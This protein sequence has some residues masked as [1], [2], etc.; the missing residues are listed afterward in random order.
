VLSWS[1]GSLHGTLPN[2]DGDP[3]CF[4]AAKVIWWRRMSRSM[5]QDVTEEIQRQVVGN[6]CEV[7][8]LGFAQTDFSG[9][10]IDQPSAVRRGENK[11]VQLRLA[12]KIGLR[13]PATLVTQDID[14][15]REFAAKHERVIAKTL[16]G[17]NT[18][19]LLTVSVDVDA[20]EARS[21]SMC[22]TIFQEEIS[23]NQHLRVVVFG[24]VAHAFLVRSPHLDW[25]PY[26]DNA[27]EP[28]DLEP[29]IR[30]QLLTLLAALD[31]HMGSFDLKITDDGDVVFLEVNPQGQFL[32]LQSRTGVDLAA[33]C[34]DYL[35]RLV[36]QPD[37]AVIKDH[38][39]RA[40]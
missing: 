12:H 39:R 5:P 15:V 4:T 34:A 18:A 25:R 11:L 37:Q 23:G 14:R 21:V 36:Q 10:W 17:S 24:D 28:V 35:T 8:L 27:V 2:S 29:T 38:D 40:E 26:T 13:Y 31:L 1:P 16:R 32:F 9:R 22:P 19:P 20:L 3:T 6:D 30:D 33:A 7:G